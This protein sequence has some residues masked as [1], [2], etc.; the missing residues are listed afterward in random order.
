M[1]GAALRGTLARIVIHPVKSLDGMDVSSARV[2]PS[3]A[4]EHDR[5]FAIRDEGG[6][7]VN[8]KRDPRVHRIR[9]RF[10]FEGRVLELREGGGAEESFALG[11]DRGRLHEWLSSHFGFP[12]AL[13]ENAGT[14]FP[15]DT[16]SPGPTLVSR[17][18]L[19][20]VAGWFP[21]STAEGMARRFRAN[22]I[23]DG[24]PP[25]GEDALVGAPGRPI[26]F[27]IGAMEFFGTN[28][29]ARCAVPTR[30]PETGAG[31]P[32]FAKR[33]A[34]RR[35]EALPTWAPKERFDHFYRLAVNT[36]RAG[37]EGGVL[38]VGD[39]VERIGTR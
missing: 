28:P 23:V 27:R 22:L 32:E 17:A 16:E 36:R 29:C 35:R 38:R 21:G 34:A 37:T 25:F 7:I 31:D 3:G 24:F 39:P 18:T 14:G 26:R 5:R 11:A 13:D 10:D 33:L 4:L 8:G 30:D 1:T 20:E 6:R 15:D 19:D 2:L 12:V 9:M